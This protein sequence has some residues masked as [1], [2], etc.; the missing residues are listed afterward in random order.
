MVLIFVIQ[1][2]QPGN[3]LAVNPLV[4]AA[5]QAAQWS[6]NNGYSTASI[7][8]NSTAATASNPAVVPSSQ[9]QLSS[10][11]LSTAYNNNSSSSTPY[12]SLP[13]G[14]EAYHPYTNNLPT[15]ATSTTTQYYNPDSANP[16]PP[17]LMRWPP[18]FDT[19]GGAYVF[20]S[21]T[22]FFLEPS[23]EFYY[24]PKNKR[25]FCGKNGMY[26][27]YDVGFDPPFRIFHPPAPT[28]T[29]DSTVQ[30]G[31]TST[32]CSATGTG[33]GSS[34]TENTATKQSSTTSS[35]SNSSSAKV[36]VGMSLG[37]TI[38]TAGTVGFGFGSTGMKKA[39]LDIAK[40]GA[41]QDDEDDVVEEKGKAG[42]TQKGL[43]ARIN[44]IKK[45]VVSSQGDGCSSL[46]QQE[47]QREREQL[48]TDIA[49]GVVPPPLPPSQ[50][51][52]P[53]SATSTVAAAA[54]ATLLSA[55]HS[56][57]PTPSPPPPPPPPSTT[58]SNTV[59]ATI[60]AATATKSPICLLC[61]RQ[62]QSFDM[63]QRHERESKL[64]AENLRKLQQQ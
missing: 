47:G 11:V 19:N 38:A 49:V 41:L 28:T 54:T 24:D 10:S 16:F 21:K 53:P 25:Y 34:A 45:K 12:P 60:A 3:A 64:H 6:A 5:L 29:S 62:F 39:K 58:T 48:H 30:Q 33:T 23:S 14:T 51:P 46:T 1:S 7:P 56:L 44:E 31:G 55:S 8:M 35:T 26:Y 61:Q 13:P 37:K 18:N 22:G 32:G 42:M 36:K 57:L 2:L 4:A 52:A 27:T 43:D 63:L 50:L 20:Q 15:T 17:L 40:W 9:H 59:T